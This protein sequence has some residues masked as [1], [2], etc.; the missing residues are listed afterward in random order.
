[1]TFRHIIRDRPLTPE[2]AAKYREIRE[3]IDAELPE[4]VARHQD[5]MAA[6]DQFRTELRAEIDRMDRGERIDIEGDE[7][8]K[9]FFDQIK[10]EALS[11]LPDDRQSEP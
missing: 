6:D 2:E 11:E 7:A 8:L 9:E 4:L 5:R 10:A 1:M 3:R